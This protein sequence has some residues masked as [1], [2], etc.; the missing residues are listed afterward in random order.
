MLGFAETVLAARWT[1]DKHG[2]VATMGKVQVVPN[3]VN[4]IPSAV[5]GWLDARSAEEPAVRATVAEISGTA[6]GAGATLTEE[7]WTPK[8][9]FDTGLVARLQTRLGG[10]PLLGTGAGHD[11]GILSTAGIPAAMLFVRNPTGVSHSPAEWAQEKDCL[12]GVDA[13][14]AVLEDL[15]G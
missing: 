2:A 14:A 4:A 12:A 6:M 11:A 8:T 15:A 9:V 5:T 3:G 10:I 13:L 7:S 1:A